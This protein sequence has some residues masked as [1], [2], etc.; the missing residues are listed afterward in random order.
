LGKFIVYGLL[1]IGAS[2]LANWTTLGRSAGSNYYGGY[3]T[4]GG[5]IGAPGGGFSSSGSGHK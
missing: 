1:V 5:W 2:S 4:R 3:G